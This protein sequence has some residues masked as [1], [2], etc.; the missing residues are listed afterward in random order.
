MIESKTNEEIVGSFRRSSEEVDLITER[1]QEGGNQV[2]SG[3]LKGKE[4]MIAGIVVAVIVIITIVI[5]VIFFILK[6]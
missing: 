4:G 2:E 3:G 1:S 6:N 5:F